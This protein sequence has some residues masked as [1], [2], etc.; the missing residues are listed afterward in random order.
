MTQVMITFDGNHL[1]IPAGENSAKLNFPGRNVRFKWWFLCFVEE[2][3]SREDN[4]RLSGH[5]RVHFLHIRFPGV[6][7]IDNRPLR[8]NIFWDKITE[9]NSDKRWS[10]AWMATSLRRQRISQQDFLTKT[11]G[12]SVFLLSIILPLSN[13]FFCMPLK[14]CGKVENFDYIKTIELKKNFV[15]K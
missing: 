14:N 1:L 10:S 11:V 12:K 2:I 7:Y 5:Y 9:N 8:I 15:K 6:G 4:A 3:F 13:T